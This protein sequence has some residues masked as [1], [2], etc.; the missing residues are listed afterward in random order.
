MNSAPPEA[1][2]LSLT[3][4]SKHYRLGGQVVRALEG[5]DLE[6]RAGEY[7]SIMGPSG[8]GKST[9]MH[10]LGCLDL[11]TRGDYVLDGVSVAGLGDDRL[12]E[13]RGRK[14]GFVFQTFNLLPRLN[15][16][17]NVALPLTYQGIPRAER[18]TRALEA[19]AQVELDQR[20]DHRPSE[21]SGGERQRVAIARALVIR[22]AIVLADEPTGN[23]D[24]KVGRE[25]LALFDRLHAVGKTLI[26][27]T[28]DEGVARRA[29]RIVRLR[30]GHKVEDGPVLREH[31]ADYGPLAAAEEEAEAEAAPGL[32]AEASESDPAPPAREPDDPSG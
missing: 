30:D 25:I 14:I 7:V 8:S 28:H 32:P 6:I 3:D 15:A 29:E 2:L 20:A 19:L 22:P 16:L 5:F 1:P 26:V 21:L 17:E 11:P 9:L 23:L 18:Q 13:I 12:A 4:V 10:L 31:D 27:V 24:S